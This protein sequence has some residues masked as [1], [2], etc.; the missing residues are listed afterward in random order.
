ML[1]LFKVG[2]RCGYVKKII[3]GRLIALAS[4]L[5]GCY[6]SITRQNQLG[7]NDISSIFSAYTVCLNTFDDSRLAWGKI[8]T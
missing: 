7:K 8:R 5:P 6:L 2:R 4:W 1:C 3:V